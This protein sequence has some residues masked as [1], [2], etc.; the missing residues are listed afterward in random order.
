MEAKAAMGAVL[1]ALT[2]GSMMNE[3]EGGA[4]DALGQSAAMGI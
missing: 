4:R 3:V 1:M 2:M